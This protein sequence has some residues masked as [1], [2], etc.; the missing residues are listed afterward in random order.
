MKKKDNRMLG[1]I[2]LETGMRLIIPTND[3]FLNYTYDKEVNWEQLRKMA[4]VFYQAYIKI[5]GDTRI[6][7]IDGK[8]A[9]ATQFPYYRDLTSS[10]PNALDMRIEN[11][12]NTHYFDFQNDMSLIFR[13]FES[14]SQ[15]F[16]E[17]SQE[18][19]KNCARNSNVIRFQLIFDALEK[20]IVQNTYSV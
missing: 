8:I 6:R 7:P 10:K 12:R 13:G 3:V 17:V 19:P 14:A 5:Y 18:K 2:Q 20:S 15:T 9:V 4:N 11:V 1:Y 16:F